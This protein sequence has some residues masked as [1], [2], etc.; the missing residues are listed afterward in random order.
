MAD[1]ANVR[2]QID[3]SDAEPDLEAEALEELTRNLKQE[4]EELVEDV[5]FVRE[6]ELPAGGKPEL[7]D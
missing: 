6:S 7:S 3:L 4:I 1:L 5:D 2:V